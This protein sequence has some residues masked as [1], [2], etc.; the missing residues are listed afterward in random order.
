MQFR[1]WKNLD[2]ISCDVWRLTCGRWSCAILCLFELIL[3]KKRVDLQIFFLW[4]FISLNMWETLAER[5]L[6]VKNSLRLLFIVFNSF[7]RFDLLA[8]CNPHLSKF[9]VHLINYLQLLLCI[10]PRFMPVFVELNSKDIKF[11]VNRQSV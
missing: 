10:K 5:T 3:S 4:R 7:L 9:R 11:D 8:L 2:E 6:F 1:R